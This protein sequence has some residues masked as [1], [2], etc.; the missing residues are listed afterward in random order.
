MTQVLQVY[1][2]PCITFILSMFLKS[3]SS[4]PSLTPIWEIHYAAETLNKG[5]SIKVASCTHDILICVCLTP[6]PPCIV[7]LQSIFSMV[8]TITF[9]VAMIVVLL[10]SWVQYGSINIHAD[11]TVVGLKLQPQPNG[12][13]NKQ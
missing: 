1:H 11:A 5:Q 4:S 10:A 3:Q 2:N 8:Y 12:W 9:S 6:L 13:Q 7:L